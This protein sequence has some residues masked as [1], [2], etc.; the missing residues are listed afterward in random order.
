VHPV[1]L[2]SFLRMPRIS[3]SF[4]LPTPPLTPRIHV[5]IARAVE[6]ESYPFSRETNHRPVACHPHKAGRH[7]S[8]CVPS[9][10]TLTFS[11]S[12]VFT[13]HCSMAD[14]I[15]HAP[16]APVVPSASIDDSGA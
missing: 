16:A 11:S 8:Y 2:G 1:D 6:T 13:I 10:L 12:I 9:F 15:V 7:C 14:T 4:E 3:K 5:L